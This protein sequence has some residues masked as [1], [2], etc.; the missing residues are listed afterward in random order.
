MLEETDEAY[1]GSVQAE[2]PSQPVPLSCAYV[3]GAGLDVVHGCS[4]AL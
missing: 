2:P 3:K 1:H 4:D